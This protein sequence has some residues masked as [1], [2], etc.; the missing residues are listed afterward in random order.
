MA[1]V[2]DSKQTSSR[3][4]FRL[5]DLID[6]RRNR[7]IPRRESDGPKKIDAIHADIAREKTLQQLHDHNVGHVGGQGSRDGSKTQTR[8]RD[9]RAN[10][11]DARKR[12]SRG[13]QGVGGVPTDQEGW[14]TVPSRP[15][16]KVQEKFDPSKISGLTSV[17]HKKVCSN[18]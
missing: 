16:T 5:Q 18:E 12:S 6:L 8:E 1:N 15:P 10:V 9:G 7:W 11:G 4:R 17:L 3:I 13:P 2:I 14:N